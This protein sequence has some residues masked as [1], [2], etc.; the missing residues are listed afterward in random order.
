MEKAVI[1]RIVDGR[2]AVILVGEDE[3]QCHYPAEKLPEGAKEGTWLRVQVEGG[4]IVA[5][6]VDQEETDTTCRR[7]QEKMNKLRSRGRKTT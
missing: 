3:R 1:D 5:M 7:I 6:E 4:E 2:T